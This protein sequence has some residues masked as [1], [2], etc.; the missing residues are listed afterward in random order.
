MRWLP[1]EYVPALH[2]VHAA[3]PE[4]END[5]GEQGKH[6][7][8]AS[9]P[10]VFE[11]VPP[12]QLVHVDCPAVENVPGPHC[13][14]VEAP[15]NEY[16]PPRHGVHAAIDVAPVILE[17][18]PA[19]H[20]VHVGWPSIANV[21]AGHT[22]HG[23]AAA[24]EKEPA[25]HSTHTADEVPPAV[26]DDVPAGHS[27]HTACPPKLYVPI[28]HEVHVAAPE[29]ENV[30]LGQGTQA[31]GPVAPGLGD[32]VPAGQSTGEGS[33][34]TANL[35][36]GAM[37]HGVEVLPPGN[38]PGGHLTYAVADEATANSTIDRRQCMFVHDAKLKNSP[39]TVN[40]EKT[41]KRCTR[42]VAPTTA[43][44]VPAG[45]SVH[46]RWLPVEYVP[47]LHWVHAADPEDENDPGE[48]GKHELNASDPAVFEY[49]PPGQLVHVDCPAV[50][51]VPGPHCVQVDAPVNE[52]VPPRHGGIRYTSAGLRLQ[53]CRQ[54]TLCMGKL[55]PVKKNQPCTPALQ[56]C[57][58]Q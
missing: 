10:A 9:A 15:V 54:D 23:E 39:S 16:V 17:D 42:L 35:P 47:A 52:Y 22:L 44:D 43:E 56:S 30:P 2:W 28:A 33:P 19:G 36:A 11:Y 40:R 3:D 46:M 27:V 38:W 4:D 49:V 1:V 50:E 6:E 25:L 7:L 41:R 8:N 20:S 51:N 53:M 31:L 14:Q 34:P 32:A 18:V 58:S 45:Q 29:N 12:G 48:Q 55:P 21:P 37:M 57:T 24:G 26:L 5:P 13:V